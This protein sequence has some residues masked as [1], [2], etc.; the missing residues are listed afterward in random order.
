MTLFDFIGDGVL[1][2]GEGKKCKSSSS[3]SNF[4]LAGFDDPS[5]FPI[6]LNDPL[7]RRVCACA[8]VRAKSLSDIYSAFRAMFSKFIS[9]PKRIAFA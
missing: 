4:P 1:E 6:L 8:C 2:V 5:R 3:S 9:L 7:C